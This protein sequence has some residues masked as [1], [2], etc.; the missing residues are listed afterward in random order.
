MVKLFNK[1][2]RNIR[3]SRK[4]WIIGICHQ[5]NHFSAQ[6]KGSINIKGKYHVYK[7][8]DL[9]NKESITMMQSESVCQNL[10]TPTY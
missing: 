6:K 7:L 1:I 8:R 3:M 9:F 2:L 10:Q 5:R 4:A